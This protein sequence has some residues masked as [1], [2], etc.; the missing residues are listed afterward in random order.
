MRV[1]LK[2]DFHLL[3]DVMEKFRV[4]AHQQDGLE[5][6]QFFGIPGLSWCSVFKMTGARVE[7]MQDSTMYEF[8]RSG[9]R[10]GMTF[11]NKHFV[12]HSVKEEELLYVD[13]NNLYGYA[14]SEPL[15]VDGFKCIV[16]SAS[17][18]QLLIELET[19]ATV[20]SDKG[21]T[22]EVDLEIPAH[23]HDKLDQLPLAPELAAPPNSRVKK[24]LL[25][26][27]KKLNYIIHFRLLQYFMELGAV[28]TKVHRAVQYNQS[29]IFK[30]YIDFNTEQR[31][32]STNEMSRDYY[33][34]KNN[35]IYGKTVENPD[36]RVN[37]RLCNS[38]KQYVTYTSK[39][40]FKRTFMI[41]DDLVLVQLEKEKIPLEQPVFIGQAVLDISKLRMYKLYYNELCDY[42]VKLNGNIDIVA[43][44]TDSF[45]LSCRN[46]SLQDQLLPVMINDGLLDTSNY[47]EEHHMFSKQFE[48]KIGLVK[49]ESKSHGYKEWVFLRPKCYSVLIAGQFY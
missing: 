26:H 42:A 16:D 15:P 39:P 38:D 40:T 45:F 21:Y 31:S 7:L 28:V 25:T 22:I 14:L 18:D 24:L 20:N 35:S 5:A 30:S 2:L 37:M 4:L 1:Y 29:R 23:L 32:K 34:L 9:V 17:L 33:K 36:K 8:F 44:D 12:K 3:A 46:I 43:G 48:A 47:P 6:L 10:G 49:D 19:M 27:R 13:V 11:V 41:S